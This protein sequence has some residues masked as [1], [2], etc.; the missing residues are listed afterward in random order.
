MPSR[1][2]RS[3]IPKKVR[4]ITGEPRSQL[5]GGGSRKHCRLHYFLQKCQN[6]CGAHVAN[7]IKKS[8]VFLKQI[9]LPQGKGDHSREANI[10]VQNMC[11]CVSMPV[12]EITYKKSKEVLTTIRLNHV[13]LKNEIS[14]YFYWAL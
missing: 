2:V 7:K 8:W 13:T 14:L 1:N 10:V 11:G 4:N 12:I 9:N 6:C 3:H 5:Y